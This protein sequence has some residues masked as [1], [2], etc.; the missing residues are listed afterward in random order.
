MNV[1][2]YNIFRVS[3][4]QVRNNWNEIIFAPGQVLHATMDLGW[5]WLARPVGSAATPRMLPKA[6]CRELNE[7][8]RTEWMPSS[9]PG[10][11]GESVTTEPCPTCK[12]PATC[13]HLSG[14]HVW[15]CPNCGEIIATVCYE[16]PDCIR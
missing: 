10:R 12:A 5:C 3:T 11:T 6:E 8:E 13:R 4:C 2:Q 14:S 15:D 9:K 16:C 7:A 1:E